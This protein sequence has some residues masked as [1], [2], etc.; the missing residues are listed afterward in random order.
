MARVDNSHLLDILSVVYV[1]VFLRFEGE[2]ECYCPWLRVLV[3]N[4]DMS[5]GSIIAITAAFYIPALFTASLSVRFPE[6][7]S[8]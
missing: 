7:T 6:C 4:L 3:W 2:L 5:I 8:A 1:D